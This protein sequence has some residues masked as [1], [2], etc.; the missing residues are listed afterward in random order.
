MEIKKIFEC[1]TIVSAK[2]VDLRISET[3]GIHAQQSSEFKNII[4][5][6]KKKIE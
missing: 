4:Q 3:Y 5:K 1:G 2:R 6:R